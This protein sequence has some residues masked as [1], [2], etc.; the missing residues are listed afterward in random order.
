MTNYK[1]ILRAVSSRPWAIQREKLDAIVSLLELKAQGGEVSAEMLAN[2]RAQRQELAARAQAN[3]AVGAVA[4]LPLYGVISHR[5]NLF[6]DF[7]GG[8]STEQFLKQFRAAR[9]EEH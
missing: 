1:R 5:M 7:S 6:S 2:L 9:S 8:A 3:A 4:V